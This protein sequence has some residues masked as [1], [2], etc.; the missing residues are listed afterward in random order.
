MNTIHQG[1]ALTE[2]CPRLLKKHIQLCQYIYLGHKANQW[3]WSKCILW[4][5][6]MP[7]SNWPSPALNKQLYCRISFHIDFVSSRKQKNIGDV[8][9]HIYALLPIF[10]H[11]RHFI[12]NVVPK[13]FPLIEKC[14]ACIIG[15]I[16]CQ[17]DV[18][19]RKIY[20]RV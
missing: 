19:G 5:C 16:F 13:L 4:S 2:W 8:V 12:F 14:M 7:T 15:T 6:Y 11:W 20:Q 3:T 9:D 1:S 18:N 10:V 17:Q